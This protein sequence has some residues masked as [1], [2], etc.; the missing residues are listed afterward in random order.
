MRS[1]N[2]FL[3]ITLN[4]IDPFTKSLHT[5]CLTET[6]TTLNQEDTSTMKISRKHIHK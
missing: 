1:E 6:Q 5:A 4:E 3:Y 2:A